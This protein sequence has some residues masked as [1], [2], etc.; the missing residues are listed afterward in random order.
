M[1]GTFLF[2]R[3]ITGQSRQLSIL[4]KRH[5]YGVGG[6]RL[7]YS[8][9]TKSRKGNRFG[10]MEIENISPP[11]RSKSSSMR[12]GGGPHAARDR[13]LLFLMFRHGLRVS[14]ACSLELSQV[15]VEDRVL[16][17]ARLKK[18][19]STTHPLH[20]EELRLIQDYL[21]HRDIRHTV[22]YTAANPARFERL[23]R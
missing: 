14:E 10:K 12:Q 16:H 1:D 6:C 5:L 4:R 15:N 13:C 17:V 7:Q 20:T 11:G 19:L 22:V 9:W 18:G 23:W 21:G 2:C 8:N 3:I